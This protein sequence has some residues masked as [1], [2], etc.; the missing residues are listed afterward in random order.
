MA[1]TFSGKFEKM[2]MIKNEEFEKICK[3]AKISVDQEKKEEFLKKLDGVL[4]W[5]QQL[6]DID[7]SQVHL[8]SEDEIP[9]EE[10]VGDSFPVVE[11]DLEQLLSNAN[12][13]KFGMFCVPKVVE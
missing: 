10:G 5:I 2:I 9:S 11:N 1:Q 7:V 6:D 12:E 3:L 8:K 4:S 13:A